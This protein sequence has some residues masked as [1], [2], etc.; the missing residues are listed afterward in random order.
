VTR[1]AGPVG[2]ANACERRGCGCLTLAPDRRFDLLIGSSMQPR[3]DY[4]GH[5]RDSLTRSCD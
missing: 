5:H 3:S 4:S 2:S 1:R